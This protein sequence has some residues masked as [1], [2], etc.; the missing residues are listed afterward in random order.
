MVGLC[1]QSQSGGSMRRR[2]GGSMR[3]RR[4]TFLQRRA[5][6]RPHGVHRCFSLSS[7]LCL[8]DSLCP[9]I[10]ARVLVPLPRCLTGASAWASC[11]CLSVPSPG[12]ARPLSRFFLRPRRPLSH[13]PSS[14]AAIRLALCVIKDAEK[15]DTLAN[16]QE[17]LFGSRY[18]A[19]R[20]GQW[21]SKERLLS[22]GQKNGD[23]GAFEREGQW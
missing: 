23:K 10:A 13:A 18:F 12:H 14:R 3:R 16:R 5:A 7:S 15:M 6:P 19:R 4:G 17:P 9:Y 20:E 21:Q 1:S 11:F 2:G 22:L 8:P